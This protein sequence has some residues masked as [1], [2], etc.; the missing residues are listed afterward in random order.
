MLCA[1]V[2]VAGIAAEYGCHTTEPAPVVE[3]TLSSIQTNIFD[4]SC[5][6]PGSCHGG[7]PP[8]AVLSL[9]RGKAYQS[10][11]FG[12]IQ[13]DTALKHYS[14]RVVP[15]KPDSSYLC[16]KLTGMLRPDEGDRMPD[17]LNSIPQQYIDA[18]KQWIANGAKDN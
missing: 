13:N 12:R 2:V 5:T 6:A 11:L 10:L 14:G 1:V 16:A 17:R 15:G 18:V 8:K 7:D 9:E 4:Q 3:P